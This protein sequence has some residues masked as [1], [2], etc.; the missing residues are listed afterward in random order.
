MR[1][2]WD[3]DSYKGFYKGFLHN[4]PLKGIGVRDIII[5]LGDFMFFSS[6]VFHWMRIDISRN[7]GVFRG[8]EGADS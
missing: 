8:R 4:C 5:I 3:L 2:G 1:G 7:V 6:S